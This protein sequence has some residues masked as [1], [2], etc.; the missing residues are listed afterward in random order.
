MNGMYAES[1]LHIDFDESATAT[2][3]S[4]AALKTFNMK[5]KTCAA[6]IFDGFSDHELSMTMAS[7]HHTGSFILETFST[8]GRTATSRGGLRALPLIT[9]TVGRRPIIAISEATLALADLG[10][11]NDIPHTG[12]HPDYFERFCP[13]YK[14]TPWFRCL[15][16]INAGTIVTV[17]GSTLM[18]SGQDMLG[19]FDTL[20][21]I[22]A[23]HHELLD[24]AY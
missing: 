16:C 17:I 10:L 23:P 3:R 18:S 8:K 6:F 14:G 11:L 24:P 19:L 15:P 13:E 9:A 12:I 2:T 21:K 5:S 4:A 22:Y 1:F 20:Q 7:L